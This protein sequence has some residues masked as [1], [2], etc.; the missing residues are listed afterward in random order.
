MEQTIY[1]K[2]WESKNMI[3]IAKIKRLLS[4]V[5]IIGIVITVIAAVAHICVKS[6]WKMRL[7]CAPFRG[8]AIAPFCDSGTNLWGYINRQGEWVIQP[9]FE[10]AREL[11]YGHMAVKHEGKWGLIDKTGKFVIPP[12]FDIPPEIFSEGLCL[13]VDNDGKIGYFNENDSWQ[14]PPQFEDGTGFSE[15]LAGVKINGKWGFINTNGTI[16]IPA[17]Y[18]KIETLFENNTAKVLRDDGQ[19]I[20]INK[21]G[22]VLEILN[23]SDQ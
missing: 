9:L 17:I 11:M 3:S 8:N 22:E 13:V 16:I 14:I 2:F 15:G 7:D 1:R 23:N 20:K 6:H 12:N 10:E 4:W 19:W 18:K 21:K 5:I